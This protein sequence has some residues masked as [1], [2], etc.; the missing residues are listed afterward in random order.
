M[1][2]TANGRGSRVETLPGGQTLGQIDDITYFRNKLYRGLRV[3]VSYI[4]GTDEKGAGGQQV[5]YGKAGM[6]YIEELRFANYVRRLQN[7]IETTFDDQ[8]KSYL[9][10]AQINIDPNL[11]RIRLAD[12]QNFAVYRQNAL[13]AEQLNVYGNVKDIDYLSRR[14][15]MKRY[16]GMTEE[17]IQ[18]NEEMLAEERG[19]NETDDGPS[20][21]QQLYDTKFEEA[22]EIPKPAEPEEEK[23]ADEP[24]PDEEVPADDTAE[25]QAGATEEKPEVEAEPAAEPAPKEP[26][27]KLDL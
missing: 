26:E 21:V 12:P 16:L 8:F 27:I 9:R 2:T 10:A 23:P 24:A 17:D 20:I 22:R 6:A 13:D 4:A 14:F 15:A 18:V 7:R 1:S 3:P 11:F 5:N 25:E 19:L